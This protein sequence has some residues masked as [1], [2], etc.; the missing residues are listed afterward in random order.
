MAFV[1]DFQVVVVLGYPQVCSAHAFGHQRCSVKI[2]GI[3]FSQ[4]CVS[5]KQCTAADLLTC[6]A[7]THL[8]NSPHVGQ[9]ILGMPI[10]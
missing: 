10:L 1:C 5:M 2:F 6:T 7:A 4:H 8:N 3:C 9:A